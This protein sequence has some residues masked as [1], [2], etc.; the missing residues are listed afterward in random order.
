MLVRVWR[1]GNPLYIVGENV[2]WCNHYGKYY[3][4]SSKK[5]NIEQPYDSALSFMGTY[6]EKI[7]TTIWKNEYI[8]ALCYNSKAVGKNLSVHQQING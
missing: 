6:L 7:K 3:A 2:N 4:G 8:A 5:Q 1:K